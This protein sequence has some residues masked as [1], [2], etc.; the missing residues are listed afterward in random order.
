[1]STATASAVVRRVDRLRG[2]DPVAALA[3]LRLGFGVAG[4]A[5]PRL[6]AR[7]F[8]VDAQEQ[9][10]VPFALRLF[11]ARNLVLGVALLRLDRVGDRR[12]LLTA[13]LLVD[14]SDALAAVA[15]G[16]RGELSRTTTVLVVLPASVE[17]GLGLS[18][19]S[20]GPQD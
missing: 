2:V 20:H 4:L 14:V 10:T 17:I 12:G 13:N 7:L 18:A 19:L 9:P 15:A 1:M 5:A 3:A 6:T 16:R 11:G 8:G